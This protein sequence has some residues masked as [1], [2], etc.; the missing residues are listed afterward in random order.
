MQFDRGQVLFSAGMHG[1]HKW[2]YVVRDFTVTM[3][4]WKILFETNDTF[5][6]DNGFSL[7]TPGISFF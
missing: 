1:M 4:V 6:S 3:R 7:S 5:V 2:L